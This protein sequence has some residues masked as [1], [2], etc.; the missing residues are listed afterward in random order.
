ML[1]L[2]ALKSFPYNLN[3]SLIKFGNMFR[4]E[5]NWGMLSPYILKDD[6]YYVFSGLAKNNSKIDIKH[7]LDTVSFVKPFPIVAEFE[8]DRWRKYSENYV[9]NNNNYMRPYYCKYLLKKWN[10]ENPTNQISELTIYFMK[11]ITLP[12]YNTK[13]IEKN[14]VCNCNI[15]EIK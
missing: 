2:G 11:E 4:L 12:D 1:N 9:F 10:T 5:Q 3:I 7:N 14:I 13:P 8:S 15:T 6:G